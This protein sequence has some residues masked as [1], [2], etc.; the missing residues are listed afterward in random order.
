[1]RL[2]SVNTS[3]EKRTGQEESDLK[4]N[5]STN[6]NKVEQILS[7]FQLKLKGF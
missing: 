6:I 5:V 4:D 3:R 7:K 1:M 2:L